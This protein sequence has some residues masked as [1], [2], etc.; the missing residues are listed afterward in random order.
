MTPRLQFALDT[1][2][3]AKAE[4][5]ATRLETYWDVLEV[6][7][8]LLLAEGLG[9]V[10][11]LRERFPSATLLADTKIVDSGAVLAQAACEAGANMVTVLSA[12][13]DRT[14]RDV[15]AEAHNYGAA[16]L[17]DHLSERLDGEAFMR[18]A[19]LGV[20]RLGLHLPKDMQGSTAWGADEIQ[21]VVQN[22]PLPVS[23]A[24]GLNPEK[25]AKLGDS[26]VDL[27]VVGGFL[28]NADDPENRAGLLKTTLAGF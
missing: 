14:I 26:G 25:I 27:F 22:V 21:R 18:Y 19:D 16:V 10:R 3:M 12:A 8:G 1:L 5:L 6:G 11:R 17:L 7:T 15:V 4:A 2:S 23:L 28:L 24:G 13:S 9:A 20:D